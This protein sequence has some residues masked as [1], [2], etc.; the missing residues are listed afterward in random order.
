MEFVTHVVQHQAKRWAAIALMIGLFWLVRLPA[1]SLT[2]RSEIAARFSF[3]RLPL[4]EIAGYPFKSVRTVHPSLERHVAWTSSVGAA[5]ALNDLDRDGLA[6]DICYV[7]PRVDQAIV[8]PVPGT[9]PRYQP[10]SLVPLELSYNAKKMAPMGCLI[11]DLN[12]D[13]WMDLLVYYWGRTPIAYLRTRESD[14]P[15]SLTTHSYVEQEII[16]SGERWYTNAATLADLDGDGHIDLIIGNY[17]PDGAKILDAEASGREQMQHSMSRAGNGGHIHLLRWT[18]ATVGVEPSVQF[19]DVENVLHER[20]A[21]GW[22][23]AVGAADLDG[24]LLPE[25]YFANDFGPDRLLHNRSKPGELEFA[26][27]QGRKT[28]TTP[29]SKV[30]GHDSFKGMGVD[31]S[32]INSDGLLDIFVSNIAAEFA[33]EESHFLFLSTGKIDQMQQGIAPYRDGSESHGLSRSGW[34]WDV[35]FGDFDN[36]GVLEALQATG[37]AKGQVNRWAELHE[38]AMGND[39]L[40]SDSRSWMQFQVGDD[41]NGHQRNAF[42]VRAHDGRFYDLAKELGLLET[43]VSRGIATADVNGDG[44]LDFAIANQW[45]PAYIYHNQSPQVGGFLGLHVLR[46]LETDSTNIDSTNTVYAGHPQVHLPAQPAIGATVTVHLSEQRKLIAQ[47]DGG[48]GHSGARSNDLHFGLGDWSQD[49]PLRV[50]FRWRDLQ[51]QICQETLYLQPGWHTVL[52]AS[53]AVS[54]F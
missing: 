14:S 34:G 15:H 29:N 25:L 1:L 39:Q 24:D 12:E 18:G 4:P 21:Q 43:P 28:L 31:F 46:T 16:P 49:T 38:L 36:D 3:T 44:D 10:F 22:A 19:Q 47:V 50:D 2:D 32:D 5:V 17:H 33:L 27:L 8:A 52:L 54:K 6:N 48:N 11:S 37:F 40:L 30:L 45:E 42:F 26:L 51:G 53:N 13:G 23:L 20:I 41:L 35:K 9:P 7:D